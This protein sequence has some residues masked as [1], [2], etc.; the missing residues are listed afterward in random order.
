MA[1]IVYRGNG[2]WGNGKGS[3][4]TSAEVD[5]NFYQLNSVSSNLV[6]NGSGEL[7]TDYWSGPTFTANV[8]VD[9]PFFDAGNTSAGSAI[10]NSFTT[11]FIPVLAG[12]TAA[13]QLQY[14]VVG[15][16]GDDLYCDILYYD[17][18]GNVILDGPNYGMTRTDMGWWGNFWFKD[19]VPA[20]AT[21]ARFRLVVTNAKWQVLRWKQVKGAMNRDFPTVFNTDSNWNKVLKQGYNWSGAIRFTGGLRVLD[22]TGGITNGLDGIQP[23]VVFKTNTAPADQKTWILQ[24]DTGSF[25]LGMANDA[26]NS[27]IWPIE[28]VRSG[29]TI[30]SFSLALRPTFAGNTPWDSGNFDPTV[31]KNRLGSV[32]GVAIPTG[33]IGEVLTFNSSPSGVPIGGSSGTVVLGVTLPAGVWLCTLRSILKNGGSVNLF[34]HTWQ[35]PGTIGMDG[36]GAATR[37]KDPNWTTLTNT[38]YVQSSSSILSQVSWY[39]DGDVGT[40]DGT[41]DVICV[42]IA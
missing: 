6:P 23:T 3:P 2:T 41:V 10:T 26:W 18:G 35:P 16:Q 20:N 32:T 37:P 27:W 5:T 19:V 39:L 25:R 17:A 14:Q 38:L 24:A 7:G 15:Y 22:Q 21:Q 12:F 36:Y 33:E 4:L 28:I 9:G 42:R 31:K 11:D 13:W 29:M 40:A 34:N 1:N 8:G 30:S